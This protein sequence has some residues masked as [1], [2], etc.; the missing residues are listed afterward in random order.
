MNDQFG[1][2]INYL[3]LS[4]T[5]RCNLRCVYCK[6]ET[7]AEAL[8]STLLTAD[9]LVEIVRAAASLGVSKI[10]LTGGEPLLRT[11][12]VPLCQAMAAVP[13]V[14]EL[15]MTTNGTL[16]KHFAG[17]L[18]KAG[19]QR[20]TVHLDTLDAETYR[21][22]TRGGD[23]NAALCGIQ[24]AR[25]AG[26]NTININAVLAK[27]TQDGDIH[28]LLE[29]ARDE[30]TSVRFIEL[31]PIG[32]CT[33]WSNE[34]FV[35]TSEVLKA[36]PDLQPLCFSGV[37]SLYRRPGHRGTIGLISPVSGRF[38]ASCTRLR[39]T[40]DGF[41]KPCLH[42]PAEYSLRGLHG[43]SLEYAIKA[44]ILEKPAERPFMGEGTTGRQ[45]NAIGG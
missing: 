5:D 17:P 2:T 15:C 41:L 3:R 16:L 18:K 38:C 40:A 22:L 4:V 34:H 25:E 9:A 45:M 14:R 43:A 13:G 20:L 1:R 30:N 31:M 8:N 11:D 44:A 23:L 37:A 28:A 42:A 21:A 26:F 39:V 36:V 6:P 24:A 29:L 10:R 12:I 7:A 27:G 19:L 33:P 35:S 32:A